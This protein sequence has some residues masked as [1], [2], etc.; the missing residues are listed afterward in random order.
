MTD[1][2]LKPGSLHQMQCR[3]S[4]GKV[5]GAKALA[6]SVL[7]LLAHFCVEEK[8]ERCLHPLMSFA[9]ASLPV[10]CPHKV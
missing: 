3:K 6:S 8:G 10:L 4:E 2:A 9:A 7:E 1:T 5:H